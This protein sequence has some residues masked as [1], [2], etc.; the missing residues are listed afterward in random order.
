MNKKT[1][2]LRVEL[3]KKLRQ[4]WDDKDFCIGVNAHLKNDEHITQMLDWLNKHKDEQIE[5][6]E[7][8]LKAME[9]RY[10]KRFEV[11]DLTTRD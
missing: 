4:I 5:S 3:I 8:A 11:A 1:N 2:P 10:G 9:I 7:V 6:D